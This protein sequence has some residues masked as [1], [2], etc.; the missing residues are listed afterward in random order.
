MPLLNSIQ[1]SNA[2]LCVI[3]NSASKSSESYSSL[4][5]RMVILCS[6]KQICHIFQS[7]ER[8]KL[9]LFPLSLAWQ[10]IIAEPC[11]IV[12]IDGGTA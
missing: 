11:I 3:S 6:Y 2:E 8:K 9:Q 7:K 10:V 5:L 4:A 1:F 12:F